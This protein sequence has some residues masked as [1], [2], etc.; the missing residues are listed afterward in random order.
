MVSAALAAD[1]ALPRAQLSNDIR[2]RFEAVETGAAMTALR[3]EAE[4]RR[5]EAKSVGDALASLNSR[6]PGWQIPEVVTLPVE[7]RRFATAAL[8]ASTAQKWVENAWKA[9]QDWPEFGA[10][11]R[12]RDDFE[13]AQSLEDL[14]AG[15]ELAEQ[16]SE[17]SDYVGRAIIA[18]D[19]DR[20]L[21]TE[22]GLWGVD[23]DTP[24]QEAKDAALAGDVDGAINKSTQVISAINNGSS[25][26]SLRLGGIVFFGIAV[27][28]VLGLW[29]MLRRQSGPSWARQTTPHWVQK[30]GS[31]FGRKKDKPKNDDKRMQP[32]R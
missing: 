5:D 29:V 21:L 14:Q 6:V 18:A 3:T 19:E 26:G 30:G 12:I 25:S 11:A 31:R 13:S 15:A 2:P 17:A 4:T 16:W 22:F 28:G 20:G 7:E 27:L 1:I 8:T 32:R 24:L 10:L 9:D 23:V